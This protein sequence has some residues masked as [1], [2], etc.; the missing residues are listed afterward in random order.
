VWQVTF[1]GIVE[2]IFV[3]L[4]S[5]GGQANIQQLLPNAPE[6]QPKISLFC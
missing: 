2:M 6:E 3:F 4:K 5:C 1:Y